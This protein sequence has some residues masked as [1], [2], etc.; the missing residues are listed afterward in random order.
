MRITAD[1]LQG[2]SR[3]RSE[4]H[5]GLCHESGDN[6]VSACVDCASRKPVRICV[7]LAAQAV[8]GVSSGV[9]Q[10][11]EGM[12]KRYQ[13]WQKI[14]FSFIPSPTFSLVRIT[15]SNVPY[16][17]QSLFS[18]LMRITQNSLVRITICRTQTCNVTMSFSRHA[19]VTYFSPEFSH[20]H[21]VYAN[22]II[23]WLIVQVFFP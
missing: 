4:Q 6:M 2:K 9:L 5:I 15:Y 11:W 8:E 22:G 1:G 20:I 7:E 17:V 3:G 23:L 12:L 19:T 18:F 21:V 16:V 14:L 13:C 10:D